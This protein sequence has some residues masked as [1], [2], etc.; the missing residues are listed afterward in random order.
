MLVNLNL[1]DATSTKEFPPR[2]LDFILY[3]PTPAT[4]SAR[5]VIP[6]SNGG[7]VHLTANGKTVSGALDVEKQSFLRLQAEF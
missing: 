2:K 3:N 7:P 5:I 1:L 4:R 6:V